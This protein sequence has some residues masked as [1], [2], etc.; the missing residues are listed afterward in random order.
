MK[1]FRKITAIAVTILATVFG[2]QAQLFYKIEKPG[3]DKASYIL[4][5]HHFA[6]LSVVD[7]IPS[8]QSALNCADKV[9]GEID[10]AA[11]KDPAAMMGMQQKLVAPADSTLDKVL[12]AAQLDS[13][14]MVWDGLTG[15]AM[16]LEMFYG[17]KPSVLSAQIAA[18]MSQKTFPDLNPMEGIDITMQERGREAGKE[19]AGLE[20][21]DFQMDMLYC[22]PIKEQAEGL[23]ETISDME[24]TERMSIALSEAYAAH[25]IDKILEVMLEEESDDA[26]RMIYSRNANWIK[27]LKDEIPGKSLFIVVGAGHLPGDRGVLKGL[28]EAGFTVTPL[29]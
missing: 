23:M 11:M 9:Y 24:K 6:T 25:N 26:E 5:T 22:R 29:D 2:C 8:L 13:L 16:P 7:S 20:T 27:I 21:M 14:S 4:G 17:M 18:I 15:G 1:K 3:S 10:M 28:Q 19:I 12:S